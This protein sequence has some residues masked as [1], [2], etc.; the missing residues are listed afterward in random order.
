MKH[1]C[2]INCFVFLFPVLFVQRELRPEE[3][4]ISADCHPKDED[5]VVTCGSQ[6]LCLWQLMPDKSGTDRQ[7]FLNVSMT[8]SCFA[9]FLF[10][11]LVKM[12]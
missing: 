7:T 4:V 12:N 3:T 11:D 6:H 1:E 5:I 9:G 2:V 10:L 8:R